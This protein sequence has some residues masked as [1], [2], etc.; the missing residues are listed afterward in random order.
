MNIGHW[1]PETM[2]RVLTKEPKANPHEGANFPWL[3]LD[4]PHDV[5]KQALMSGILPEG[6]TEN[7]FCNGIFSWVS[8]GATEGSVAWRFYLKHFGHGDEKDPGSADPS[9]VVISE[10]LGANKFHRVTA[11]TTQWDWTPPANPREPGNKIQIIVERV[12]GHEDDDYEADAM[13]VGFKL[14]EYE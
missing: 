2:R 7:A 3:S 13:L 10:R 12:A 9:V 1:T 8:D 4:F 14:K 11:K 5:A 6:Y